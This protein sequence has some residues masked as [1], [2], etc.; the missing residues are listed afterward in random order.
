MR[1][2][3]KVLFWLHLIAGLIGGIVI[4]IMCVTGAVLSFEKNITEWAEG[5]QRVV[6]PVGERLPIS[7]IFAKVIEA[8]PDAK[9][10]GVTVT[11][12]PASAVTVSL[13]REGQL[14][15][16]PYSGAIKGQG[17]PGLRSFFRFNTDLHRYIAFP[18]EARNAGKA[19]TGV[20]NLLFLFLAVSGLYI[21]LPR[22][23]SWKHFRPV[24]W[25]R[26]TR[27]GKARDFN[28]HNVIG[29]WCSLAL[30][31]FTLTATVMSYQ[32]ANNLLYTLSGSPAPQQQG[33]G[34]QGGGPQGGRPDDQAFQLPAN[35][36]AIWA[37]GNAF[38]PNAKS[39]SL[40][41]PINKDAVFTID[42]GIYWNI[43]G[44]STLTL[45]AADATTAKWEPYGERNTGQQL[46]TWFRFLHT[47]ESLGFTGQLIGFIACIGG[48]FLVYT[49]ISLA[50]R[51]FSGWLKRRRSGKILS[52]ENA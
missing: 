33:G 52:A 36:D 44:R 20:S 40:R 18:G 2:F 23:W 22:I 48:A 5:G 1:V 13:G 35:I 28:W 27:S 10:S 12:D 14:F 11:N 19:L 29:F 9:P 3:R 46:R 16:D 39:V 49:G 50:L 51:R 17:S 15:V 6:S 37:A 32:W 45:N 21:W 43:F 31:V 26:R 42:E 34:P 7:T 4:L 8:K 25:F 38:Y 30:I 24:F 41:L 47:G